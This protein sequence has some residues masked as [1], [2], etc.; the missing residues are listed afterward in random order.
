MSMKNLIILVGFLL[1]LFLY[2]YNPFKLENFVA[3][4]GAGAGA[5]STASSTATASVTP[6]IGSNSLSTGTSRGPSGASSGTCATSGVSAGPSTGGGASAG[7][8]AGAG[9]GIGA[10]GIS[11]GPSSAISGGPSA[12]SG[13]PSLPLTIP[14]I[15]NLLLY[16]NSFNVNPPSPI[17]VQKNNT[18]QCQTNYWCD[19]N[20]SA[21]QYFL[22]G[23]NVPSQ[24]DNDGLS[25]KNIMIQGP[26]SSSLVNASNGYMIG[27]F[28]VIFYLNFSTITFDTN[29][30]IML[31][32]MYA[33]TP[34]VIRIYIEQIPN[35]TQ[36]IELNVQVGPS[37]VIY[38]WTIPITTM[39]SNGNNTLYSLVYDADQLL[40][41]FYIGTG[42][43]IYTSQMNNHPD[44]IL[45]LQQLEINSNRNLDAKILA[46]CYYNYALARNDIINLNNYFEQ[47]TSSIFLLQNGLANLQAS[48]SSQNTALVNQLNQT[49][50]IVNG[51]ESQI[52]NMSC[53][54]A[55]VP[56]PV[57]PPKIPWQISMDGASSVGDKDL[58]QCSPL[59]L[60]EFDIPMPTVSM[61]NIQ[62]ISSVVGNMMATPASARSR[63][64]KN[65]P[66]YNAPSYNA[67]SN[68]APSSILP[69]SITGGTPSTTRT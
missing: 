38:S 20:N 55:P 5:V 1:V 25:I 35:D 16:F 41:T 17:I 15:K 26:Q 11:G 67:P 56:P 47:E 39:L 57:P 2:K 23:A 66:S 14:N 64:N 21:I 30:N 50:N 52:N 37:T 19:T 63:H 34:N 31:Y 18:Y 29:S 65:K 43:N 53:P 27:S 12:I 36:N 62:N 24:I 46:F 68:N 42:K 13:V 61:P 45:G 22:N 33:Q 4:G 9:A 48:L 69:T 10:S 59:T 8:S 6:Q 58:Q 3:G 49:T 54:S 7:A 44:I 40:L 32:E 51:L 28:S 60:Q